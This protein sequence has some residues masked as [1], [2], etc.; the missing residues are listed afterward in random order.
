MSDHAPAPQ[1]E[2]SAEAKEVLLDRLLRDALER[3]CRERIQQFFATEGK[4]R[5]EW[6]LRS[7]FD[8]VFQAAATDEGSK[9]QRGEVGQGLTPPRCDELA[10]L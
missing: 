10:G 4:A 8:E 7:L 2:V 9:E 6:F 1:S 3:V 5:I